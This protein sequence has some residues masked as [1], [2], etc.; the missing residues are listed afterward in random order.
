[1]LM[2][3]GFVVL[4]RLCPLFSA[5]RL[6]HGPPRGLACLPVPQ[7]ATGHVLRRRAYTYPFGE[8]LDFL[9]PCFE[10]KCN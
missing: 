7:P 3:T 5:V 4:S 2:L 8:T 10:I 1:M 6:L 9:L